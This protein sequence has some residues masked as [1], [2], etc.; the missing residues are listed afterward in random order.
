M[1][2][3][4]KEIQFIIHEF[5][6][7]T[8]KADFDMHEVVEFA[9]VKY[10][11]PVP[12]PVTGEEVLAKMFSQAAR[13]ETRQDSKTGK[14]YRVYHAFKPDGGGQ[15]LFHWFDIDNAKTPRKYMQ[16]SAVM[17]REQVIGDMEQLYL[18]LE[19]W[20]SQHPQDEPIVLVTDL[21][22]DIAERLAGP[23]EAAA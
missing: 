13:E 21:T 18:D 14:S 19:H 12:P 1:S 20:N 23:N 2:Q 8:G 11:W 15:G 6:K 7:T 4:N 16:K 22:E 3:R 5:L 10:N 17:R 9:K